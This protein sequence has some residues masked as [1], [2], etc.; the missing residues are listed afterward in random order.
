MTTAA[1]LELLAQVLIQGTRISQIVAGAQREGRE[2]LTDEEK[3]AIKGDLD[4]AIT[5]LE[6][7]VS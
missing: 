3:A 7:A 6:I 5:R 1:A 4:A 2:K